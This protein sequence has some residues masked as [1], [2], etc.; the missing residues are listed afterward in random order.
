MTQSPGFLHSVFRSHQPTA[1]KS[2]GTGSLLSQP[3]NVQATQAAKAESSTTPQDQTTTTERAQHRSAPASL[4]FD[5]PQ[6]N[7][8]NPVN[9]EL[10][11]DQPQTDLL[12]SLTSLSPALASAAMQEVSRLGL[13]SP[14]QLPGAPALEIFNEVML[15][16]NQ[17]IAA[18]TDSRIALDGL[19]I[20]L[21]RTQ[22]EVNGLKQ[23]VLNAA[24]DITRVEAEGA[25]IEADAELIAI[26]EQSPADQTPT[27]TEPAQT[28][29]WEAMLK[30]EGFTRT[31]DGGWFSA[32]H[33]RS[34]SQPGPLRRFLRER[35][36]HRRGVFQQRMNTLRNRLNQASERLAQGLGR[37]QGLTEA[38]ANQQGLVSQLM[39][40][41]RASTLRMQNTLND[42][43]LRSQLPSD[44]LDAV[45]QTAG[46]ISNDLQREEQA[47]NR[48]QQSASQA[49]QEALHDL[50]E[51]IA[52]LDN[53]HP[54]GQFTQELKKSI[55]SQSSKPAISP[56]HEARSALTQSRTQ[57]TSSPQINK[58]HLQLEQE[59]NELEQAYSAARQQ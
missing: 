28:R 54:D 13:Q 37:L 36:E 39:E 9:P 19:V 17:D 25:E 48:S 45:D 49:R 11:P 31:A 18:L 24:A 21:G 2:S 35:I 6:F 34:F 16:A 47:V 55:P 53:L 57:T 29:R 5:A 8:A 33:Q 4:N 10:N 42:P 1:Q 23:E 3:S 41:A 7:P 27:F 14:D 58:L 59:L 51:G 52:L 56:Y 50:A 43:K 15:T 46:R 32:L 44:L 30:R 40:R 26:A 12:T 20:D 22:T 38:I